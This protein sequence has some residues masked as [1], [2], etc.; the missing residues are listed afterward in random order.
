M[1]EDIVETIII[2]SVHVIRYLVPLQP[3]IA[4]VILYSGRDFVAPLALISTEVLDEIKGK[5]TT[6]I[7]RKKEIYVIIRS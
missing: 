6:L 3:S 2:V 7:A 5:A 1:N 4:N